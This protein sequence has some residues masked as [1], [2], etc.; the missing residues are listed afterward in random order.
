MTKLPREQWDCF[1]KWLEDYEYRLLELP[2]PDKV[3]YLDMPPQVSQLLMSGRYSGD[4]SRKDIHEADLSFQEQ[5]RQ[6]ALYAAQKLGWQVIACS[7]GVNPRGIE[8]ISDEIW[9]A[10]QGSLI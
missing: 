2:S 1:L 4:E 3:I 10:V 8:Q 7:D 6:S 5:C 9:N